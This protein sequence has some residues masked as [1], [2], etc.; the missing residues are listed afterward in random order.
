MKI[1]S[2]LYYYS[3]SLPIIH[4]HRSRFS[5]IICIRWITAITRKKSKCLLSERKLFPRRKSLRFL[6]I[7][8][9]DN[10]RKSS[11]EDFTSKIDL[12]S[13]RFNSFSSNEI[14]RILCSTCIFEID[15][16]LCCLSFMTISIVDVDV[17][18]LI[19]C[20]I[21]LTTNESS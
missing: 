15:Q 11:D 10:I 3:F 4:I 17:E 12:N 16:T 9:L 14:N 8:F 2:S 5:M 13:F 6:V 18:H 19:H 1:N 21:G 20:E 7:G